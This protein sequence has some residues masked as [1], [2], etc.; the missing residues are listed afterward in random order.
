[1]KAYRSASAIGW[2]PIVNV[3]L[4]VAFWGMLAWQLAYEWSRNGQYSYGLFVPFLAL[5]LLHLRW[6]DHPEPRPSLRGNGWFLILALAVVVVLHYPL[7]IIF[8]ANADW[9]LVIWG[10]ALLVYAVTLLLLWRWGGHHW[11]LHFGFPFFFILTAI[12]WPRW[13]EDQLVIHLM[14]WVATATV[15]TVNFLGIYARQS[16]NIITLKTGMVSVE[17]ACSGVRSF[18]STIMGAIFLGELLRFS[19]LTRVGLLLAGSCFALFFNFCRTLV[20]TIISA[21]HGAEVMERWHD[22]A[23][24]MVFVLSIAMLGVLCVCLRKLGGEPTFRDGFTGG[25]FFSQ[26]AWL[27]LR[28]LAIVLG[29]LIF[30]APAAELWYYIRGPKSE[31][32]K[33]W[34]IDWQAATHDLSFE[35]IEPRIQEVLF[36]DKGEMATWTTPNQYRWIAYF[37]EWDSGKAAQ[38]G[39]V[40]NPEL[41]LPAVGWVMHGS[42]G[43]LVWSGAE[44]LELIFNTYQF[45]SKQRS[46]F[47]FYC[48]WDPQGYPY[49]TKIGRFRLDRLRD[50]WIGDRKEGK[51][52]LEIIIEGPL[53]MKSAEEA[54]RRFL[55]ESIELKG[56]RVSDGLAFGAEAGRM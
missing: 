48:Q 54:L 50:A 44:G 24:Y 3:G 32:Q 45:S 29:L 33:D 2:Q 12:P 17:E 27:P 41:C 53:S 43:E 25:P 22:P 5:Y 36:Y 10:Q 56:E 26:P 34:V 20:L 6:E 40:H 8:E 9:R 14:S 42:P 23:G 38:L 55:D 4:L 51:Q 16:G 21:E 49:H 47:V 1:M 11:V 13:M 15:E 37:F 35:E 52:V 19:A 18:Q 28:P 7:K 39:G 46:V 30:S 31:E